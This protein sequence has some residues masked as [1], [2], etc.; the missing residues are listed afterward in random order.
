MF[1]ELYEVQRRYEELAH[2]MTT[3]G[4]AADAAGY[5][6]LMRDYKELTPLIET[7]QRYRGLQAEIAEEEQALE[8]EQ[9]PAFT[10][11]VQ[12]ELRKNRETLSVLEENLRVL[13]LPR[14][15]DDDKSIIMEIRAGTG[16][17]E[18]ALFARDLY[19][20]Y[21]MYAARRGWGCE[22]VSA[23]ETELGGLKEIVFSIE[24][25]GVYSRLKFESGAH[26]VQRVPQTEAQGRIQ[27]SAAT[28]AVMPEAEEV[29]LELDPRDLRI[30]TFRAS[31]AGGQHINKTSSAIRV[32]HLPT[33]L[34]VECQDQRSQRENRDRALKVLRSRLLQQ[35]QQAYDQEY[36]ARR[37]SQVG[38][39]DRSERIRTYNFPQGRLTDHRIGLTIYRLDEVLDGDLDLV[40]EPLL[41]AD[42]EEKLK[43]Q[44]GAGQG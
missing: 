27:T 14:D 12:Q 3:P 36:N 35:K 40:V 30:D 19:R 44:S 7:W 5:A 20:M 41:L 42:R 13:L 33:G 21:T 24:G 9:D 39:G 43:Q 15:A 18:A 28:V 32:T 29:E 17:E 22:T 16:G 31:G 8:Q 4:A 38:S 11:M 1:E 10:D 2:R 26:R 25:A 34:V 23:S 6:R 37:Q